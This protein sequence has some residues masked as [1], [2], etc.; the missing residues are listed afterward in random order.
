VAQRL[1]HAVIAATASEVAECLEDA[2]VEALWMVPVEEGVLEA[3][4]LLDVSASEDV[5]D[6]LEH[7]FAE[8][9]HFRLVLLTVEA[10]LPRAEVS[11][12]DSKQDTEQDS[13]QDTENDDHQADT[14]SDNNA[15]NNDGYDKGDHDKNDH[16]KNDYD[17]SDH[18]KGDHADNN[19]HDSHNVAKNEHENAAKNSAQRP[20]QDNQDNAHQDNQDNAHQDN[21]DNAHQDNQD[22]AHQDNAATNHSENSSPSQESPPSRK[23]VG[24]AKPE[25]PQTTK[26]SA[27]N[28]QDQPRQVARVS[29]EELYDDVSESIR[30]SSRYVIMVVLS[31]VVA[32]AGMLRNDVAVIIGA[33][34]IAPLLGTNVALSLATTLADLA[35]ARRAVLINA[36]GLCVALVISL[37]LGWLLP[38]SLSSSELAARTSVSISDV[39]IALAAGVAGAL[40]FTGGT[41]MATIGVMVAVALLPPWVAAGLLLGAGNWQAASGALLLFGCNVICVNLAG[42]VTFLVQGLRPTN[43]REAQQAKWASRIALS[44]WLGLLGLLVLL[45]ILAER[46]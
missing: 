24:R 30:V 5:L 29:R 36:L 42:V 20:H 18:D 7:Y 38:V 46:L 26:T 40:A 4:L 14:H 9:E 28:T 15:H 2:L 44:I 10:S 45:I 33:M 25:D 39:G 6:R 27:E 3:S 32:A 31:T 41:A 23:S 1:I 43:W 34:V 13:K 19:A 35:L 12:Q 11:E 21:Q 16:K 37:A 22:N 8:R 17:K